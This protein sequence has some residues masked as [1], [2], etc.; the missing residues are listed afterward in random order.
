[1]GVL[2]TDAPVAGFDEAI[3]T[4]TSVELLGNGSPVVIFSGSETLD[5]LKLGDFSELF[6]VSDQVRPGSYS[7]IRLRLSDLVLNRLDPETGEIVESTQTQLVGNGKIDLN[8]RGPFRLEP[9]DVVF[10]ELDFDM[11]KSLKITATGSGKLIVRPVVFVDIRTDRPDG[12]LSRVHGEIRAIDTG[13]G[14]LELCQN[15]FASN[16]DDGEG[17]RQRPVFGEEHCLTVRTDEATG[18]FDPEGLPQDFAGLQVG[19]E[20]TAVGRIRRPEDEVS[21]VEEGSD[22]PDHYFEMTA[23]VIEEG[24]LST[25]SRTHGTVASPPEALSDRFDFAVS[26]GQ[27]LGSD[28]TLP[29]Q[30]F[31]KSRIFARAGEELDRDAIVPGR[32]AL[33]DGVLVVGVEDLIRSPLVILA[34]V[35]PAESVL[36][37]Q[38]V[39]VDVAGQS[40]LVNDGTADRCVAAA[41]ADIFLVNDDD[42]F[43][44]SRGEIA[45]LSP[46]QDAVVF[47][48]EGTDGCFDARTILAEE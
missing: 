22:D 42:G 17:A 1:V 8:P 20:I 40:L 5:L 23:A 37:G 32:I 46:G 47:G 9:G 15:E 12:R 24:P 27:G 7:K 28:T 16:W 30:L 11:E 43:S 31:E 25:Y 48:Q 29:V 26:A 36:E 39:D 2:L 34:P 13:A 45:D 18:I 44:S 33:V 19:D 35:L 38:V 41:G 14:T 6:A 3:A 4:I 10:V 21:A